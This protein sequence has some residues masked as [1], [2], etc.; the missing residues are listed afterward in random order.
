MAEVMSKLV[1][2][3][4]ISPNKDA[5]RNH[6]IDSVAIHCMAGNLSVQT[7]G[8]LFENPNRE[9]SSNYGIDSNGRIGL[10]VGEQDRSWCTSSSGVDN[11]AITIEV[12]NTQ[13]VEPFQISDQAYIS[14]INLLADICER[15]K[16]SGLKWMADES[17]AKAAA[18]G[19]PV[20]KQ[21]MFVHRWFEAKSCPGN[22]LYSIHTQIAND[23]NKLLISKNYTIKKPD[24]VEY[25]HSKVVNTTT[26]PSSVN[27]GIT[28][29][30][31]TVASVSLID[32]S[33]L[34]PYIIT[35]DRNT[36]SEIDYKKLQEKG[37]AGVIAEAGYLFTK[38]GHKVVSPF[39]SPVVYD[40]LQKAQDA[41]VPFGVY[42]NGRGHTV[43]E[44]K[45][46]IEELAFVVRKY[47]PLLGVWIKLDDPAKMREKNDMVVDTY[48]NQLERLGLKRKIGLKCTESEINSIHW[49]SHAEDWLLWIEDP[50]DL[51]VRQN[52]LNPDFFSME[53]RYK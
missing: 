25:A 5:P 32:T 11:R 44:A 19:G 38:P 35:I 43:L 13:A 50:T 45:R 7:C 6:K 28:P 42:M 46:E 41:G 39:R 48:R 9:A 34:R 36:K 20:E 22:Y 12:A 37:V 18:R 53:G 16:I 10:Y 52:L 3:V 4:N 15:N 51:D 31:S 26:T 21:N 47:A 33:K 8:E 14:L 23:V 2:Y 27:G 24:N 17:Y 29:T 40:Q 49:R 30:V 1:S